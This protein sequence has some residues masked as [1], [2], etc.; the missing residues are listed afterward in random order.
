MTTYT[1]ALVADATRSFVKW[2]LFSTIGADPNAEYVLVGA[3]ANLP[4]SR[5]ITAGS[6]ITLT[7]GGAGSTLTIAATSSGA[8]TGW[9]G[10]G[11]D[12]TATCDGSTA[13]AGMTLTGS[14]YVQTRDVYFSNLTINSGVTVLPS[15]YRS[16]VQ[17]TLTCN[18]HYNVDGFAASGGT[19]GAGGGV[20]IQN[21]NATRLSGGRGGGSGSAS[22]S[23]VANSMGGGGGGGSGAGS[24][25]TAPPANLGS[26]RDIVNATNGYLVGMASST[27]G[28][29]TATS[30]TL[31][32]GGNGGRGD[33]TPT[34][35]GGGG[36]VAV[37]CA[38]ILTGSGTLSANG[39]A[40]GY[41]GPGSDGGGGGGGFF[42]LVTRTST[43]WTGTGPTATGGAA[44]GGGH[45]GSSG[46]VVQLT[47]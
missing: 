2:A 37:L 17:N 16:F 25:V 20:D 47:A 30:I 35:G 39:G 21:N 28:T 4:N 44:G 41:S 12:G 36:G 15:G 42:V 29:S 6:G 10:D 22:L 24:S 14:T 33:G 5:T 3:D 34:S 8:G 1:L 27:G 31:I 9:Y 38:R 18:G 23:T 45:A 7:D 43:G 13:V 11:S 26:P 32:N 19:P 40:G 46:N